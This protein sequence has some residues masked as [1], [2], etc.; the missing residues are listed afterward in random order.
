DKKVM[1]SGVRG[2]GEW[3]GVRRCGEKAGKRGAVFG[4]ETL[5]LA[6]CFEELPIKPNGIFEPKAHGNSPKNEA[7]NVFI[8]A[9]DAKKGGLQEWGD[10][11]V[12]D[13]MESEEEVEVIFDETVKFAQEYKNEG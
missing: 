2:D 10:P 8:S 9:K 6:Q 7:P 3:F 4:R 11:H 13:G 5:C 12:S 1:G